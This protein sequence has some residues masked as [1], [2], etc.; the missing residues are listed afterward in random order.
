MDPLSVASA[1]SAVSTTVSLVPIL[2]ATE[3]FHTLASFF[4]FISHYRL[5]GFFICIFG[6]REIWRIQVRILGSTGDS[7]AMDFKRSAQEDSNIIAVSVSLDDQYQ[8]APITET[9][10]EHNSRPDRH[11]SSLPGRSES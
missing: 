7:D 4:F 5:P 8:W 11:Y 9:L 2:L 6:S 1:V 10:V 3:V